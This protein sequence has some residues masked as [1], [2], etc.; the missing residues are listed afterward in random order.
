M[1]E[2]TTRRSVGLSRRELL[3]TAAATAAG[4]ATAAAAQGEHP[5]MDGKLK[6]GCLSWCFHNF[7][8]GVDPAEAI[9][10]IGGMGFDGVELIANAPADLH[11]L[12]SGE[13]LD[14]IRARVEKNKLQ[15]SQF[16]L[17]QQA[18]PGL[19][20]PDQRVR[21]RSIDAFEAGCAAAARLGAPIVNIV[22]PWPADYGAERGYLPRYY[23][24]GAPKAG[25][26]FHIGLP[27][28]FDWPKAWATFVETVRECL[29][30]AAAHDVKM[31]IE[32]HTHCLVHDATAFLM[33]WDAVRDERL[34]YNLDSGWTLLQRE[35]PPLA[36]HK[37]GRR[38]MNVHMRDIDGPM[39]RFPA[40][41]TGVMDVPAI[42]AACKKV[43][44]TGF[45]SIEQDKNV[46]DMRE[47][48]RRYL[49]IMREAIG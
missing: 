33:L 32:H 42:V 27:G 19:A 40:F 38:L 46:E 30:R 5:A 6:V 25:E 28:D 36:I 11:T 29:R 13:S 15:V 26:R 39:R 34:G 10:V 3:Q 23:E 12:W 22:A 48:C 4:T 44:F 49:R 47:T 9:D 17:F 1:S 31:T 16:V 8:G 41:G 20:S 18:V 24:I 2:E 43:G 37:V 35:Y 7:A 21:A 45:L 14:R